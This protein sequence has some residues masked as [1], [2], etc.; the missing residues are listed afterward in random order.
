LDR[1]AHQRLQGMA[2]AALLN[3]SLSDGDC[4]TGG[5]GILG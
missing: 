1:V 4:E 2:L 5:A 3:V